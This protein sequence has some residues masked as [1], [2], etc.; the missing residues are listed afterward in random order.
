M[1]K[2]KRKEEVGQD[3]LECVNIVNTN[4]DRLCQEGKLELAHDII[5]ELPIEEVEAFIR[6][7]GYEK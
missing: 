5:E 6:K 1:K 4:P 2:E 7:W 3:G